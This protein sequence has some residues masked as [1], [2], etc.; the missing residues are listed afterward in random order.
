MKTDMT[1]GGKKLEIIVDKGTSQW[2]L[3]FSP[4]GELPQELQGTFTSTRLA[5]QAKDRYLTK[6]NK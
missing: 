3:H 4:G 1:S 2:R 5:Q 6:D